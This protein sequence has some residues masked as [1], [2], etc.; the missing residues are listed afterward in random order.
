MSDPTTERGAIRRAYD[1]IADGYAAACSD[2]LPEAACPPSRRRVGRRRGR[3]RRL[4]VRSGA[5]ASVVRADEGSQ[6]P[7]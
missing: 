7:R 4:P 6:R 2:D 1:A 5:T 3:R